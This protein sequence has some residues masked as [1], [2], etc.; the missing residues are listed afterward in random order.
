MGRV[1]ERERG[2]E[3]KEQFANRRLLEH[4]TFARE[5]RRRRTSITIR[6]ST[7]VAR[8]GHGLVV[9]LHNL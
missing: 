9:R 8:N 2:D 4:R 6:A 3:E 7:P 5:A 1:A